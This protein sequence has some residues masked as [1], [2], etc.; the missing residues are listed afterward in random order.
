[1][2]QKERTSKEMDPELLTYVR[3][4]AAVDTES[5]P[6]VVLAQD[7][8]TQRTLFI[9][10]IAETDRP[11]VEERLRGIQW[12]QMILQY[13]P[14]HTWVSLEAPPR[15][16]VERVQACQQASIEQDS[17]FMLLVK[18][19]QQGLE[20]DTTWPSEVIDYVRSIQASFC[21][22]TESTDSGGEE[23]PHMQATDATATTVEEAQPEEATTV[24]EAQPEEATTVEEAQPEEATTVEE[25]PSAFVRK[26]KGKGK[27]KKSN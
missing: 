4:S 16:F 15:T 3:L 10:L 20:V 11:A 21:S 14:L 12:S 24:E 26:N 9:D 1:M 27:S 17:R 25:A 23:T 6:V 2:L 5:T 18:E 7:P 19:V 8:T 13:V 22:P